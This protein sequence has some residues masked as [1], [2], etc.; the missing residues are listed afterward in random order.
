MFVC[1]CACSFL[2]RVFAMF[3]VSSYQRCVCVCVYVCVCVRVR[4]CACVCVI[5][6]PD[7]AKK[8]KNNVTKNENPTERIIRRMLCDVVVSRRNGERDRERERV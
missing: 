8:I 6:G 5:G 1:A 2:P 3:S 4:V 7:R